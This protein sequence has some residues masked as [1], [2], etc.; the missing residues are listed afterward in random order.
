VL[1]QEIVWNFAGEGWNVDGMRLQRRRIFSTT[2]I[3]QKNLVKSKKAIFGFFS[4]YF[5]SAIAS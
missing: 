5:I 1:F 4:A 3:L 2:L